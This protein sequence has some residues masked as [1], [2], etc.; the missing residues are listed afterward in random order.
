[1]SRTLIRKKALLLFQEMEE[2]SES[3]FFAS[4]GKVHEKKWTI[5]KK[6]KLL[7]VRKTQTWL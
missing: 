2:T 5:L 1:M 7:F 6:E 4:C 3:E